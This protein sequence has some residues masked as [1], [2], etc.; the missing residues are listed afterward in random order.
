[1]RHGVFLE[2]SEELRSH[3]V[4]GR[5]KEKVEK[6]NLDEWMDFDSQLANENAREQRAHHISELERPNPH[7]PKQEPERE[8]QED[9]K[10]RMLSQRRDN[11]RDHA[12][13]LFGVADSPR[14]VMRS[15]FGDIL[16]MD[17]SN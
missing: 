14:F 2:P 12:L 15:S 10:L 6:H 4:A 16:K 17:Y 5:E 3:L 9:C 8:R 13:L 7:T 11:V 1:M